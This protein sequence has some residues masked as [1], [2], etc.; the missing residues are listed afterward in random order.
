MVG[1]RAW[2]ATIGSVA[3]ALLA[4]ALA[5]AQSPAQDNGVYPFGSELALGLYAI[6][7]DY[8]EAGAAGWNCAHSYQQNPPS[9]EYLADCASGG[10]LGFGTLSA[11][12]DPENGEVA[13]TEAE[14]AGQIAD[15]TATGNIAFWNLP[16]EQRWWVPSEYEIVQSYTAW[17][18]QYDPQQLPTFM[19]IPG[20]Y[21]ANDVAQ[22]APYL[23]VL[24]ASCYPNYMDLP[25]SYVRWSIERT[26]AGIEASGHAV[27]PDYL[28]GDKTVMAILEVFEETGASPEES[29]HDFWLAAACDVRGIHVYA[30]HY[31][32]TSSLLDECYL[33]LED[34]ARKFTEAE[35]GHWTIEGTPLPSVTAEVLSGPETAPTFT[36]PDGARVSYPSV[37]VLAKAWQG[38][39][40][41]IAVSSSPEP[42]DARISGLGADLLPGEALWEERSVTAADG[43]FEAAFAPYGVH[44]YRFPLASGGGAG[45]SGA[46]GGDGGTVGAGA[47]AASGAQSGGAAMD[48]PAADGDG[49]A[50]APAGPRSR[51]GVHATLAL[52]VGLM[53]LRARR[54]RAARRARAARLAARRASP[55]R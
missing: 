53:G 42:V 48:A 10:L 22:Y 16:E 25:N 26:F 4:S 9:A 28:A 12:G 50:T 17:T 38:A 2:L 55:S 19:Y 11:K 51:G 24:P 23:D 31:R 35:L 15:M 37:K 52:I 18:R 49:C 30:Y 29:W 21:D 20:H 1:R 14:I 3:T 8:S 34:A 36:A 44:V 41:L 5:N 47:A 39:V 43:S 33:R 40:T 32:T 27:G 45:G 46:S 6:N 13:L 54:V 7:E